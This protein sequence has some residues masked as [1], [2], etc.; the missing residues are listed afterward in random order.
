MAKQKKYPNYNIVM[1]KHKELNKD[2]STYKS[3]KNNL[4]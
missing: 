4:G 3:N 2:V 1:L